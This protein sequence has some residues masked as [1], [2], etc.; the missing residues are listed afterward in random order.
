M[1]PIILMAMYGRKPVVE[2]NL[3]ITEGCFLVVTSLQD[4]MDFLRRLNL[5][6]V[7]I[8][9]APNHP[10]GYKWQCGVEGARKLGADP[11]IILGS[12]DFLSHG[13]VKKAC[14]WSKKFDFIYFDKFYIHDLIEKESFF[15]DYQMVKWNK[16]P[17]GSGRIYSKQFLDKHDWKLFDVN[18]GW[19]LDDF[20]WSNRRSDILELM[21][22]P[23]MHI[24]AAKGRWEQKNPIEK[25][26]G[27]DKLSWKYESDLNKVFGF[28]IYG[29]LKDL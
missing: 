28:D 26:L 21:N 4:D 25:F 19:K 18:L 6:N 27:H 9:P 11:L 5:P 23:D 12:D 14:E 2:V 8:L 7:Q 20:A 16:P 29:V 17:I 24:L 15:I 1:N 22:P 3:R 13:F 10:L